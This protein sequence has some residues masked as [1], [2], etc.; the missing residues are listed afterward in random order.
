MDC[1]V[2]LDALLHFHMGTSIQALPLG[3]I[4]FLFTHL[5]TRIGTG[6]KDKQKKNILLM[7]QN[8]RRKWVF[9]V[10]NKLGGRGRKWPQLLPSSTPFKGVNSHKLASLGTLKVTLKYRIFIF[11]QY[12]IVLLLL[13]LTSLYFI[14]SVNICRQIYVHKHTQPC[15]C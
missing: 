3:A 2:F 4:D 9:K 11:P 13:H 7:K 5:I 1:Q 15:I 6:M 10:D 14:R 12:T 8:G